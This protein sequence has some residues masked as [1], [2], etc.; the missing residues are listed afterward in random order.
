MTRDCIKLPPPFS[1]P[2]CHREHVNSVTKR[3]QL[4]EDQRQETISAKNASSTSLRLKYTIRLSKQSFSSLAI[5][6]RLVPLAERVCSIHLWGQSSLT[7]AFLD[8]WRCTDS[9][10]LAHVMKTLNERY[11]YGL[12]LFLLSIDEGITGYRDDSL[13]VWVTIQAAKIW[14]ISR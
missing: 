10:V 7:Y 14:L 2:R 9:T 12:E 5:E 1:S 4:S 13:E 6:W 8:C 11:N 3:A